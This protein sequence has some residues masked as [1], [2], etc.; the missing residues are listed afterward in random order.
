MPLAP[1]AIFTVIIWVAAICTLTYYLTQEDE[2]GSEDSESTAAAKKKVRRLSTQLEQKEKEIS[3]LKRGQKQNQPLQNG[4]GPPGGNGVPG[5]GPGGGPDGGGAG[6]TSARDAET[7]RQLRQNMA[8][9]EEKCQAA[10][11][12]ADGSGY[13]MEQM[14]QSMYT[15]ERERN[16]FETQLEEAR[17]RATKS[18]SALQQIV[19]RFEDLK[20]QNV[21]LQQKLSQVREKLISATG[22]SFNGNSSMVSTTSNYPD[23]PSDFQHNLF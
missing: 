17:R 9:L 6:V 5:G 18:S 23:T 14:Q 11:Q 19:A 15:L 7:I 4:W 10:Q 13:R 21:L 1:T 8:A 22:P 12:Q 3:E 20:K 16:E 2:E